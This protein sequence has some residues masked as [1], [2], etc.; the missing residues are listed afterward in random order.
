MKILVVFGTRPEAIKMCPL[1]LELKRR[2][3]FDVLVCTTGQHKEL[4]QQ[5][6]D[7]FG[8]QADYSLDI[9]A[10]GQSLTHITTR[11]LHG[12]EKV[13]DECRPDIVLVH[14]D[15][16]TS[17]AAALA[18]FYK[19]IDVGHVEAGLRTYSRY[20]PYPEEM[21]RILVSKIARLHFA[22]TNNNSA[23]LMKEGISENVFVTGN[24]VIDCFATTVKTDYVFHN[25]R[26][27]NL[28]FE[29]K[30]IVLTAHRRENWGTG[31]ENIC[32][33]AKKICEEFEDV[34]IVYPVHPNPAVK[35]TVYKILGN[36][37]RVL[38]TQSLDVEDMHNL[39]AK[40]FFVMTDSGGLQEEAPHFGKP[41]M[42]LRKETERPEAVRAGTAV[43][44]GTDSKNILNIASRLLEDKNFYQ[45]MAE[46]VNPY[47]DGTAS[48]KICDILEEKLRRRVQL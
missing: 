11:V 10:A 1:V 29:K 33:S 48:A 20:S 45:S 46:A 21:N 34:I 6:L 7:I 40:C 27:Q 26:L 39:V 24:T 12:M 5:V 2:N 38:L 16:T 15:T 22:P 44:V 8:V 14:G 23:A 47:G 35:D 32:T 4:L 28:N 25:R 43:V 9:M 42:V 36:D 17:F 13:L 30:V 41:V 3:K 31:I 18:A 37:S 19:K